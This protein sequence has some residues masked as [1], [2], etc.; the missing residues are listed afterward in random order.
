VNLGVVE[1]SKRRWLN[2]YEEYRKRREK[3]NLSKMP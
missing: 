3:E 2:A 1:V